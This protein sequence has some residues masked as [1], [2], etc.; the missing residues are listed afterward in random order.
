[1]SHFDHARAE[2]E[3]VD[4]HE[5]SRRAR[6]GLILFAIYF[7][8]YGGFMVLNVFFPKLMETTPV[9]GV[10]LAILYGFGLIAA[11]LI[12]ALVYAWLCRPP[13]GSPPPTDA[14]G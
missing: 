12:L 13:N 5:V 7:V 10:N 14:P 6:H 1:M 8:L 4:E 9:A 11:A 3:P 2:D